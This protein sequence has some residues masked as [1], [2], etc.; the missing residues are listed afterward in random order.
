M[1][2]HY[3]QVDSRGGYA[4]VTTQMLS[5]LVLRTNLGS[6]DWTAKIQQTVQSCT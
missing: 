3:F 6:T 1:E 2:L 4:Y 5:E